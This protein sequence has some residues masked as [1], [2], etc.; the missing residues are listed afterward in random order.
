MNILKSAIRTASGGH[1]AVVALAVLLTMSL[2]ACDSAGPGMEGSAPVTL[3]VTSSEVSGGQTAAKSRTLTDEAG[4]ELTIDAAEIVLREIEFERD[5]DVENCPSSSRDDDSSSDGDDCEEIERGPFLVDVPLTAS[6]PTAIIEAELP[7]GRWE[8]IEFDVHKLDDDD[9]DDRQLLEDTGFPE[10]VS[11]RVTGTWT[12]ANG[13]SV[14][15]TYTSDLNED[16]EIELSPPLEVTADTPGNV[17]FRLAIGTWFRDGSGQL[18]NPDRGNDDGELEDLIE[19]N[20][21]RS[22]EAFEDDDRD[23]REDDDDSDDDDSSDDDDGDDS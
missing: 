4:N 7:V 1:R 5:D 19:D 10:D 8:E 15:F 17:T 21:E 16:Q 14:P 13:S 20:I 23:G 2:A 12:P 18:V 6:D 22:I 9:P 3:S 11:I